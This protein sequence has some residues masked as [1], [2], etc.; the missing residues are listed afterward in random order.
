MTPNGF[1]STEYCV[2][3][4]SIYTPQELKRYVIMC[5]DGLLRQNTTTHA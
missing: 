1:L 2:L 5:F 4:L 3:A